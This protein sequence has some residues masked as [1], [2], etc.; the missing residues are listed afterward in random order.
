[1]HTPDEETKAQELGRDGI[2]TRLLLLQPTGSPLLGNGP[3]YIAGNTGLLQAAWD[4]GGS[5]ATK[6]GLGCRRLF[7]YSDHLSPE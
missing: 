6:A 3:P 5:D 7:P 4:C 1:M 2:R